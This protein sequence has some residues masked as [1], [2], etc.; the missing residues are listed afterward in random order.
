MPIYS[1]LYSSSLSYVAFWQSPNMLNLDCPP[2]SGS[3][4]KGLRDNVVP[5]YLTR[6]K[7]VQLLSSGSAIVGLDSL[8]MPF[9]QTLKV[10][11][12]KFNLK[13]S[14]IE[15]LE[16]KSKLNNWLFLFSFTPTVNDSVVCGTNISHHIDPV[17]YVSDNSISWN[18][19]ELDMSTL[20]HGLTLRWVD[21]GAAKC[22]YC[23]CVILFCWING[24]F[25]IYC[26]LPYVLVVMVLLMRVKVVWD[27]WSWICWGELFFSFYSSCMI[28]YKW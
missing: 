25:H 10:L 11:S 20:P 28:R 6:T 19:S 24:I 26:F 15:S 14:L 23:R 17:L 18:R 8:W 7:G 27:R 9:I 3:S 5:D 1:T 13:V 2:P 21:V 12:F 16:L 4:I 22:R